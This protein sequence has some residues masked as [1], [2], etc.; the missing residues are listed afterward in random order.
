MAN[1]PNEKT[2][3]PS[4]RDQTAAETTTVQSVLGVTRDKGV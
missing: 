4:S 2:D 1:N 3:M